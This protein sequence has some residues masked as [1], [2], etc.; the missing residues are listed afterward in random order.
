MDGIA[1]RFRNQEMRQIR[2]WF[3][4]RRDLQAL[5]SIHMQR[6]KAVI[7]DWG[8]NREERGEGNQAAAGGAAVWT[9]PKQPRKRYLQRPRKEVT[10]FR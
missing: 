7:I 10:A 6:W 4:Q 5:I 3:A 8:E 9:A 1:R 2:R